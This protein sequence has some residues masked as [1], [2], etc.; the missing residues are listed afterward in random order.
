MKKI[1]K[2][3]RGL[4]F[5]LPAEHQDRIGTKFRYVI[6]R[7][8]SEI[9][10]ISDPDGTSTVSR[11]KSGK[12]YKPLYDIRSQ[13]VRTLV[14][15]ADYM[16]VTDASDRIIVHIYRR[17]KTGLGTVFFFSDFQKEDYILGE[18]TG[19][20]ILKKASG[21][22][23]VTLPELGYVNGNVFPEWDE[24]KE[25]KHIQNVY[26]TISLFSGAGLLDY[27]FKGPNI[28]FVY[29][30]DFDKDACLT[31]RHNIGPH[32]HCQD[33]ITVNEDDI[34]DGDIVIGGPC[35]QA[36]S[37]VNHNNQNSAIAEQK[38]LLIDDFCRIVKA[39]NPLVF[40]MENVPEFLT[41]KDAMYL[42]RVE[43]RLSS[44]ALSTT[45]LDDTRLGGYTRRK[46]AIVIG[47]LIGKIVLP[48]ITVSVMHTVRDALSKVDKSW[49]NWMDCSKPS[50]LTLERMSFVPPGGN[51]KDL[52]KELQ[53]KSK[54]SNM[55]R[56]LSWDE[57]AITLANWRKCC[58]T[59][60]DENRILN[61]SEAAALMGLDKS[62]QVYGHSLDSKQ[63]QIANGVTQHMGRF[64][65]EHILVALDKF[66]LSICPL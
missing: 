56:R 13:E 32:I 62:F 60:P 37:S 54:F 8:K 52:P 49:F 6:S 45:I 23:F 7:D 61:V 24:R 63:Q 3:N 14:S 11:K 47:S 10:I 15:E 57:P 65:K 5:S 48:S 33:I 64:I 28:R 26:D 17:E 55:Y 34:P 29:A 18:K 43:E 41:Q 1:K 20:I 50:P 39:K 58:I 27:S 66:K 25:R 31:Y 21:D 40:V 4:T 46:R 16:E 19:E 53:T 22:S 51:W 36:Y 9:Y 38:R 35:C 30:V 2:S 59:H 44:Y 42:K 12:I